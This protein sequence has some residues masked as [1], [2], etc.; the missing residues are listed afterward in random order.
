MT[1]TSTTKAVYRC[2]LCLYRYNDPLGG[3]ITVTCPETHRDK[4]GRRMAPVEL[5][6]IW[7]RDDG[8]EPPGVSR[9]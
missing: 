2:P 3:A 4:A 9:G 1:R 8:G 6:R 7:H 5:E